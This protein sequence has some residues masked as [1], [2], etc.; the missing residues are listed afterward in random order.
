MK[1][2]WEETVFLIRH[3]KPL[4]TYEFYITG[5]Q[6][7]D[8]VTRAKKHQEKNEKHTKIK[9]DRQKQFLKYVNVNKAFTYDFDSM[10]SKQFNTLLRQA[11]RGEL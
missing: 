2:N 4:E 5:E 9:S 3:R 1:N 10:S 8:L 11:K 6:F 7:D